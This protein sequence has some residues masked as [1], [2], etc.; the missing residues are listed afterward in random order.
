MAQEITKFVKLANRHPPSRTSAFLTGHFSISSNREA[1]LCQSN[2]F[3]RAR[4]D[5]VHLHHPRSTRCNSAESYNDR[6]AS[7][8][9]HC[10][11]GVPVN[12]I[13]SPREVLTHPYACS[14]VYDLR[15]FTQGTK[16]GPFHDNGKAN[17]D[18]EKLEAIMSRYLS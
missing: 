16:W 11:Y 7:A 18:W 14:V 15:N 9:I 4:R 3:R 12:C 17:V 8:K 10:L 2:I 6:Q 1:F 13:S 5:A